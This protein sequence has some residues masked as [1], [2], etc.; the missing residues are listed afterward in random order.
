MPLY[1]KAWRQHHGYSLRELARRAQM[2]PTAY[3]RIEHGRVSPTVDTL[4]KLA[5]ALKVPVPKLFQS[6]P[7]RPRR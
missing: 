3:S 6:S 2:D 5:K 4:E 1:L 7:R